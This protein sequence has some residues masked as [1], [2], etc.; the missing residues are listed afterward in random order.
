VDEFPGAAGITPRGERYQPCGWTAPLG[1]D[2]GF[3]DV[4]KPDGHHDAFESAFDRL[5]IDLEAEISVN[6]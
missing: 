3:E 5:K 1:A 2:G 6:L 4:S